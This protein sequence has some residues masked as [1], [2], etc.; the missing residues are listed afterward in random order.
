MQGTTI[1]R[2][3]AEFL[4]LQGV[5]VTRQKMK[6][7]QKIELQIFRQCGHFCGADGVENHLK[8]AIT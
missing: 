6:L 8:H 5:Q 4:I 1:P 3:T 7:R 2:D